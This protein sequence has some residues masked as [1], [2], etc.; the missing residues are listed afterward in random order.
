MLDPVTACRSL[1]LTPYLEGQ[2]PNAQR[3]SLSGFRAVPL[4]SASVKR[5]PDEF[6]PT[7]P[8]DQ[9]PPHPPRVQAHLPSS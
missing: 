4:P 1:R 6:T 7:A 5:R 9:T 2:I 3:L 8:T